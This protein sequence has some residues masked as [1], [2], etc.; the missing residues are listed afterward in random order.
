MERD[1]KPSDIMTREAF[2]N[3]ITIIMV[4]GGSTNAAFLAMAKSVGVPLTQD[5]F[6]KIS[7]RVPV[8]ADF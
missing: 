4:L 6:Q 8:L 1:I 2:E 5:D 3:A 7:D